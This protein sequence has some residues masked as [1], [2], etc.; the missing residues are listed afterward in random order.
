MQTFGEQLTAARKAKGMTQEALSQAA[1]VTRQTVSSWERGRTIPDIDTIRRLS[2]ILG[3]DLI[4]AAEGQSA[5]PAVEAMP[6]GEGQTAPAAGR[7]QIKKRWIVAGAAVLVCVALAFFLLF[8]RKPAPAGG[9]DVFNADYYQQETANEAGKAYLTFNNKIWEEKGD[10]DV[11]Q[12][13]DFTMYEQNGIAFSVSRIEMQL[14]GK[15]GV[16]RSITYGVRDLKAADINP[17]IIAYG[18]LTISGGFPKGEFSRAGIAVYG[19]DANDAP[20]AFYN[21]IEF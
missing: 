14:L 15:S 10:N 19:N 7:R 6:G 18:S 13:Y 21:L 2:D 9:G 8:P 3:A 1:A 16:V 17:E 4:P 11:Y 20:N 5:A 12:R